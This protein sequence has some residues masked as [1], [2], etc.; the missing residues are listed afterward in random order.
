MAVS[1]EVEALIV[2]FIGDN[3]E[4]IKLLQSSLTATQQAVTAIEKE[5][6]RLARQ[7]QQFA[8]DQTQA[9]TKMASTAVQSTSS[10][11]TL[12]DQVRVY[13][14]AV[15]AAV[16]VTGL[17][18][19]VVKTIQLAAEAESIEIAF[20][21]IIGD[22]QLADKTLKEL[23][24]FADWSPFSTRDVLEA[25]K[26]MLAM[27]G[28]AKNLV[29]DM[30]MIGDVASALK[31]PLKDLSYLYDKLRAQGRAYAIDIHQIAR[32]G[33]PI[34]KYL[35]EILG[36]TDQTL[37]K[38]IE[39]GAVTFA[40]VEQAF[41]NMT[42]EGGRFYKAMEEQSK[43][44]YGLYEQFRSE[45]EN[46]LTEIGRQ[47]V[48]NLDLKWL[49]A[50]ASA[51]TTELKV[52]V[53]ELDPFIKKFILFT[54]VSLGALAAVRIFILGIGIAISIISTALT[55]L[56]VTLAALAVGVAYL[57]ARAGGLQQFVGW[58]QKVY[59]TIEYGA[60]ANDVLGRLARAFDDCVVAITEFI[61]ANEYN[62]VIITT[63]TITV[64][65]AI[66]VWKLLVAVYTVLGVRQI[67]VTTATIT[68]NAVLL[69][70]TVIS[71][72][73]AA[74]LFV[75]NT[76][77]AV[78]TTLS[79]ISATASIVW[80][81]AIGV[82]KVAVWLFNA[83]LS[84]MLT[85][86]APATILTAAVAITALVVVVGLVSS[87]AI[88]AY[89]SGKA[90]YEML[91]TISTT[92]GPI[93][94]IGE[95]FR[96]WWSILKDVFDLMETNGEAAW[97]LLA[98][99]LKLAI[100][101]IRE[102]WP[103]LWKFIKE[104]FDTL[105][106]YVAIVFK[107]RFQVALHS[108]VLDSGEVLD[109]LGVFTEE[110]K[111]NIKKVAEDSKVILEEASKLTA[112]QLELKAGMFKVE[113]GED[114]KKAREEFEKL[115]SELKANQIE[116]I[117]EKAVTAGVT[118][119]AD[120]IK[121]DSD[122]VVGSFDNMTKHVHKFDAAL[123]DSAEAFARMQEYIDRL[124]DQRKLNFPNVAPAPHERFGEVEN[125]FPL[126]GGEPGRERND[127]LNP[128]QQVPLQNDRDREAIITLLTRIANASEAQESNQA[129][130]LKT[131]TIG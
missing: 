81:V 108:F 58:L 73:Y 83:A 82:A 32:H 131:A 126:P 125:L 117:L 121:R 85:L 26:L 55:P 34:N 10:W 8:N 67:L 23:R 74:S 78:F 75:V 106:L 45:V 46:V 64:V 128:Q 31:I 11:A 17:F 72:L 123:Y 90:L 111:K 20:R 116:D 60:R 89:A 100:A 6:N 119:P 52:W 105:G 114:T 107:T 48:A 68:W 14:T 50:Q 93:A 56:N 120:R 54:A 61:K 18:G 36:T 15:L 95:L 12:T 35:N 13:T 47:I 62:I 5:T 51:F 79:S 129:V 27:G 71:K 19:T 118:I 43:T 104:G 22:A 40:H 92:T 97:K 30:E 24:K 63:L 130:I 77:I 76:V 2:R 28:D 49:T 59:E 98:A 88:A 41:K 4:Y 9:V 80:A 42:K 84:V 86:L 53:R 103:P 91:K 7:A 102:L 124:G 101:E 113:E 57:A 96:E 21:S 122:S 109:V 44:L 39:S 16:G 70:A 94:H 25:G 110:R 87:A 66:A 112:R 127:R 37:R 69:T 115:R 29:H 33:V 3:S 1:A 99:G 38:A 65:A